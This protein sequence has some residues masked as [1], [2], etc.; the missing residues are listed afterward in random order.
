MI[1][2]GVNILYKVQ[3]P[4]ITGY[5]C[6]VHQYKHI[7]RVRMNSTIYIRVTKP[8]DAN[9]MPNI[10]YVDRHG[11]RR[12]NIL[13]QIGKS[14]SNA[15]ARPRVPAPLLPGSRAYVGRITAH[16][17]TARKV[18]CCYGHEI[19]GTCNTRLHFLLPMS[20]EKSKIFILLICFAKP[21]NTYLRIRNFKIVKKKDN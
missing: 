13:V 14:S 9:T 15:A 6:L 17:A 8:T 19:N 20:D 12:T 21:T 3:G 5:T 7:D 16:T 18:S 10:V 4:I 11:W 1:T 2:K